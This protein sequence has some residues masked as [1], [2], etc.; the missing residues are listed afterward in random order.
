MLTKDTITNVT[1]AVLAA[2]IT[3][4]VCRGVGKGGG[5]WRAFPRSHPSARK[6]PDGHLVRKLDVDHLEGDEVV[7][8]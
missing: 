1:I 4:M 3:R 7:G 2:A 6:T 8:I 5:A